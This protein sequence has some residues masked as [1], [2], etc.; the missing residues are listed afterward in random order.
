MDVENHSKIQKNELY[1]QPLMDLQM[2]TS[3]FH[4][5]FEKMKIMQNNN[6]ECLL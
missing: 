4:F 3:G 2:V 6:N 1:N 5:P